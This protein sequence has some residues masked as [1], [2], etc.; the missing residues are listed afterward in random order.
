[1]CPLQSASNE[2]SCGAAVSVGRV[3]IVVVSRRLKSCFRRFLWDR[4]M[5]LVRSG[6][7]VRL[8]NGQTYGP[9]SSIS[10]AQSR[11]R[12]L[13]RSTASDSAHSRH[14]SP[15][16][17]SRA[18]ARCRPVI[19]LPKRARRCCPL[20]RR[21]PAFDPR[22]A[23][24]IDSLLL[25]CTVGCSSS[26]ET[27]EFVTDTVCRMPSAVCRFTYLPGLQRGVQPRQPRQLRWPCRRGFASPN[28]IC[29]TVVPRALSQA[30]WVAA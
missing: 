10:P 5:S 21:R 7:F 18:L 22:R 3:V 15:V 19:K 28:E 6:S 30:L 24:A 20:R 25:D 1:M 2:W 14:P 29:T 11:P 4:N 23:L 8:A 27:G 26:Q 16:S 9:A 13:R 12:A 17:H